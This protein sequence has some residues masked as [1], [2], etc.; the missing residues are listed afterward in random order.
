MK[1]I[2]LAVAAT[3]L[4]L[5]G[6]VTKRTTYQNGQEVSSQYVVKRPIKE[7]VQNSR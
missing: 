4:F 5:P 6:C 1:R 3:A 7:A 2:L